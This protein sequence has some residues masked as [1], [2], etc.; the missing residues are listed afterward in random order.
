M[1]IYGIIEFFSLLLLTFC[2][3]LL[4]GVIAEL[5]FKS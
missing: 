3:S 5:P 2:F 4:I 1:N